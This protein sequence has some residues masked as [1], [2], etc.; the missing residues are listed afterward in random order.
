MLAFLSLSA[1]YSFYKMKLMFE[2]Y[3]AMEILK[4][5]GISLKEIIC[6]YI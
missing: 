6:I 4:M 5:S 1:F 2:I 3:G